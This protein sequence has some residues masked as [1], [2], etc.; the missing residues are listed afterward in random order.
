MLVLCISQG[1]ISVTSCSLS[2]AGKS[3]IT[4]P[5]KKKPQNSKYKATFEIKL[6][7]IQVVIPPVVN[8]I[9]CSSIS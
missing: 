8:N 7:S 2:L 4:P 5:P 1:F 3:D 9:R 6:R